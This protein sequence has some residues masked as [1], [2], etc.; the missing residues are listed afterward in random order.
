MEVGK[1]C[2]LD[3]TAA[4]E[5]YAAMAGDLGRILGLE[6]VAVEQLRSLSSN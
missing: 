2:K 6:R 3:A 5:L 1:E 4:S